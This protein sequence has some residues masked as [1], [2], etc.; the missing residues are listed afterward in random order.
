MYLCFCKDQSLQN[1]FIDCVYND[2]ASDAEASV[3]FG[4]QVCAGE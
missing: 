3:Q 2:C 4:V 1:Y